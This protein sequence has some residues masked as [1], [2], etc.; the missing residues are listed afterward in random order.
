MLQDH[1]R[2]RRDVPRADRADHSLPLALGDGSD[3]DVLVPRKRR[4]RALAHDVDR[5]AQARAEQLLHR[6]RGA[7]HDARAQNGQLR[8]A[9]EILDGTDR[10]E[11]R[12]LRKSAR[13][14][15][16]ELRELY[17]SVL[18]WQLQRVDRHGRAVGPAL[19][20]DRGNFGAVRT[21]LRGLRIVLRGSAGRTTG[22][23][24]KLPPLPAV[25]G[26]PH[27]QSHATRALAA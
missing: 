17:A 1:L 9:R 10:P 18:W 14:D 4:G 23:S 3:G 25:S 26:T 7:A 12:A 15:E 11:R 22:R 24:V 6:S 16:R 8:L 27:D 13:G 2:D 19:P 21:Y 20:T 5:S